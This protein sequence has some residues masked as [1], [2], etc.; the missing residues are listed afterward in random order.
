MLDGENPDMHDWGYLFADDD[1]FIDE[2]RR[3]CNNS[4]VKKADDGFDPDSF[5]RYL[6]VELSLDRG[7]EHPEFS[8]ITKR[9]KDRRVTTIRISNADLMLDPIMHEIECYDGSKQDFSDN[10]IAENM[11][12]NVD[13]EGHRHL[14]LHTIIDLRKPIT[15]PGK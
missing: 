15:A 5:D 6:N 2:F 9:L 12:V 8:K 7:R 10:M 1:H 14:V 4:D 13:E 11:F 3:A